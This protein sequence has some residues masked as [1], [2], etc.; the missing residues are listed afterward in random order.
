MTGKSYGT[1]Y[2]LWAKARLEGLYATEELAEEARQERI[3][4]WRADPTQQYL[5]DHLEVVP[6]EFIGPPA[7]DTRKPDA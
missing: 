3:R 6:T 7:R 2:L 1:L 4:D 5:I